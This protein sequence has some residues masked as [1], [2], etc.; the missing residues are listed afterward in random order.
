M[1]N[2]T[3]MAI[4]YPFPLP[5]YEPNDISRLSTSTLRRHAGH[6]L[7]VNRFDVSAEYQAEIARRGNSEEAA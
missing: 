6:A 1:S 4:A 3:A 7:S 5:G 2:F